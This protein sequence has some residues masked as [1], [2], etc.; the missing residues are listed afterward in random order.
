MGLPFYLA[1]TAAEI[2]CAQ[3]LPASVAYM[4]C[5]FSPYSTGLSNLP[6]VL[7]PGSILM[8]N[9]RI[10]IHGHDP[11]RIRT[12]LWEA[13]EEFS[14]DALVLDLQR[15]ELPEQLSLCGSLVEGLPCPVAVSELYATELDCPV[16]LSAPQID[17]PLAEYIAPYRDR[18]IWL[19]AAPDARCFT[20]TKEGCSVHPLSEPPGESCL[21]DKALHCRYSFEADK[22]AA[23]FHLWRTAD[24]LKD[25]REPR[26]TRLIGLYQEFV[27]DIP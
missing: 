12:Q 20:V 13:L 27:T 15:P 4:A 23:R 25:I 2:R 18:E 17:C 3:S 7:P 19:E 10:P 1:M 22:Q 24:D 5:H 26:I 11:L 9:D 14:C 6:D 21:E 16:F 8:L